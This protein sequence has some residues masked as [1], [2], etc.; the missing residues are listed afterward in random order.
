MCELASITPFA[1]GSGS[2]INPA[3]WWY[4]SYCVG[5]ALLAYSRDADRLAVV[6][7][8]KEKGLHRCK[9]LIGAAAGFELAT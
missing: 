7:Q 3:T 6:H 2:R 9:P 1:F 5:A 4:G 8:L